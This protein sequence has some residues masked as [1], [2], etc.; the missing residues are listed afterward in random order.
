L[1]H[2]VLGALVLFVAIA[3]GGAACSKGPTPAAAASANGSTPPNAPAD[4]RPRLA[5]PVLS[6][7]L[8]GA[9]RC[10][11]T[12]PLK[13]DDACSADAECGPSDPCHAHACVAAARAKPRAADTM[14]TELMDCKSTDANDCRCLEGRCALVPRR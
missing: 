14:C 3:V 4:D 5:A 2:R 11:L 9:K 7:R 1:I 13:S 12:E 6:L 8:P 10:G